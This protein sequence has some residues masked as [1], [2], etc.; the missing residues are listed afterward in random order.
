MFDLIFDLPGAEGNVEA[1]PFH[2]II[3]FV[4]PNLLPDYSLHHEIFVFVPLELQIIYL[5]FDAKRLFS[6]V[7]SLNSA[8]GLFFRGLGLRIGALLFFAAHFATL[9]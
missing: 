8:A 2:Q 1:F 6:G 7:F 4:L 5:W 3:F 9:L